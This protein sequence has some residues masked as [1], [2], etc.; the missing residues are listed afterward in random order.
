M[1]KISILFLSLSMLAFSLFI[2][3]YFL[4]QTNLKN[5]PLKAPLK[6][7]LLTSWQTAIETLK[8]PRS[9]I[10]GAGVGNFI[11]MF[12]LSKTADYNRLVLWNNNFTQGGSFALHILT[13]TG[14]LGSISLIFF[15]IYAFTMTAEKH[16]K[17]YHL[18]L[19]YLI[20]ALIFAPPSLPLMFLLM[21]TAAQIEREKIHHPFILSLKNFFFTYLIFFALLTILLAGG[22][23]FVGKHALADLYFKKSLDELSQKGGGKTYEYARKSVVLSPFTEKYRLHFSTLNFAAAETLAR[24]KE[25]LDEWERKQVAELIEIAIGEA[26]AAVS[27]GA[28]N[29]LYWEYLASLY[30]KLLP[31]A[32]GA[33]VWAVA[34]YQRAIVADPMSPRLRLAAGGVFYTI[35]N[36]EEAIKLFEQT[37][38]LKPDWANGY[39]NLAWAQYQNKKYEEAY[40]NLRNALYLLAPASADFEKAQKELEEFAKKVPK[41]SETAS[42]AAPLEETGE[43]QLELPPQPTPLI[44]PIELPNEASPEATP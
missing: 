26:K 14:L 6:A 11:Q 34:A 30:Q 35:K 19:L 22:V 9:A 15:F 28:D 7:P 12:T 13:E 38:N 31:V 10:F 33:D 8:K 37:V 18:Y 36:Y 1:V 32:K 43:T 5:T 21:A 44:S 17:R 25:N 40:T 23:Y 24:K 29:A 20:A 16:L 39:Y 2:M 3:V 27:F 42:P 4:V 41:K